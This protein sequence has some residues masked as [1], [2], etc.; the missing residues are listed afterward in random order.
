MDAL[1]VAAARIDVEHGAIPE[2]QLPQRDGGTR[3]GAGR[4][5]QLY[6]YAGLEGNLGAGRAAY[7]P[8]GDLYIK[9]IGRTD[10]VG[11]TAAFNLSHG[12][13]ALREAIFEAVVG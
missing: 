6:A 11:E 10:L 4:D 1:G 2:K 5:G 7:F 9:G 13:L 3:H 8:W 12:D